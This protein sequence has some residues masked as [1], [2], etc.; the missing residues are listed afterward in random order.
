MDERG[1]QLRQLQKHL[2]EVRDAPSTTLNEKLLD[3]AIY[4]LLPTLAPQDAQNLVLQAFQLLP[5]LQQN[6]EPLARLLT[7]LLD[8]VPLSNLLS[9]EAPVDFVAGLQVAADN[10]I[11]RLTLAQ[12]EK[13]DANSAQSLASA[14]PQLFVALVELWLCIDDEGLA[15][16]AAHVLLHL[17]K[18]DLPDSS[19]VGLDGPVWKRVFRDKDVYERIFAIT[20]NKTGRDT[21]LGKSAKTIAQSRLL[22]WLPAVGALD[23]T[24]ISQSYHSEI[25]ALYGLP[26]DQQSLL[27]YVASYMVDYRSD[28]LMHRTL[29]AFYEALLKINPGSSLLRSPSLDFLSQTG[30]HKRT[31]KYYTSPEDPAHDP[32]DAS[33]LYSPAAFYT[34][35]WAETYPQDLEDARNADNK[36][37]ILTKTSAALNVSAARWAQGYSPTEDLHVLSSLPRSTLL[38]TGSAGPVLAI[39]SRA[40]N[41]DA[42]HCLATIFHGPI[43]GPLTFPNPTDRSSTQPGRASKPNDAD[44]LKAAQ[45]LYNQYLSQNPRFWSDITTHAD[46]I[47]LKEPALAAI[48]LIKAV[49]TARWGGLSAILDDTAGG[50]SSNPAKVAIV[51]WLLSPPKTFSNLVGGHGDA[52]NAAYE[53]AMAKFDVLK[54]LAKDAGQVGG[55]YTDIAAVA[56]EKVKE[57]PW[58]RG[59]EVGGRI[60]TLEL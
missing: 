46:T 60:A 29:I 47:A 1:E 28:V 24:S 54:R 8:P 9:L 59:Q 15:D 39:P 2:Q 21:T 3:T 18:V 51:P 7:R 37:K 33:F 34:A 31:L 13:A 45:S 58:G 20:D 57:G 5:T 42:L 17:L 26:K 6:P 32:L 27:N 50:S 44:E 35:R 43:E 11:N 14:H 56:G 12:L 10:S 41:R 16:K 25:E 36:N 23:W 30:L 40:A 38:S 52:E 49:L 4:A 22:D 19:T 55:R 53:I 48:L